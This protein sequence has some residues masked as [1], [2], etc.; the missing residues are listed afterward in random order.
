MFSEGVGKS[1]PSKSAFLDASEKKGVLGQGVFSR[2]VFPVLVD[3]TGLF[4]LTSR[5]S[6]WY[7]VRRDIIEQRTDSG[8]SGL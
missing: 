2:T 1:S 4:S 3:P 7:W 5:K 8:N 6:G